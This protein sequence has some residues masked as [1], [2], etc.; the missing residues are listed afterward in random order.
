LKERLELQDQYS[1]F[2]DLKKR[3]IDPAIIEIN[4][5]TNLV[6]SWDTVKRGRVITG[7]TF[8]IKE[9]KKVCVSKKENER[10]PYTYEMFG[11]S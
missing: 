3:I 9:K 11:D 2:F 10:C 4:N 6:I 7:L 8:S 1:R 5:S